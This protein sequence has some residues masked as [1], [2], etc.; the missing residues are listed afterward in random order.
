MS[1]Q[2]IE[3][4]TKFSEAGKKFTTSENKQAGTQGSK[5]RPLL[6]ILELRNPL[7]VATIARK[8]LTVSGNPSIMAHFVSGF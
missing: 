2:K 6:Y 4:V 5:F 3:L 8:T 1:K 7:N